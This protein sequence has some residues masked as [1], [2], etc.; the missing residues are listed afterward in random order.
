MALVAL[1]PKVQAALCE[2]VGLP[3]TPENV[4]AQL[5]AIAV[6]TARQWIASQPAA[7]AEAQPG[8]E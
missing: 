2:R 7:A 1:G 3:V 6:A 8:L 5:K 4:S